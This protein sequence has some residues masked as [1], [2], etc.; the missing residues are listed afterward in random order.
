MRIIGGKYLNWGSEAIRRDTGTKMEMV[1]V[2]D[3]DMTRL[4]KYTLVSLMLMFRASCD[5][6]VKNRP[7]G[8]PTGIVFR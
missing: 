1:R 4:G 3:G 8:L 6:E 2:K 7:P 5:L